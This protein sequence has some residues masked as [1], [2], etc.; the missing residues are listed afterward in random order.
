[1]IEPLHSAQLR[2]VIARRAL[3]PRSMVGHL[4]LEQVI[5]VRIPGGQPIS[6]FPFHPLTE[7]PQLPALTAAGNDSTLKKQMRH[8]GAAV[9]RRN[10]AHYCGEPGSESYSPM[11]R[12]RL[13]EPLSFLIFSCSSV[14]A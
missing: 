4:P 10:D 7:T 12:A 9:R 14:M 11:F 8:S 5:G 6:S 2:V 13:N 1:M 3:P